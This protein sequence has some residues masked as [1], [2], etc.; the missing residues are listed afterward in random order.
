M[1]MELFDG[2]FIIYKA[3]S[4]VRINYD[5]HPIDILDIEETDIAK[6]T[7]E[8][9][10]RFKKEYERRIITIEGDIVAIT[11]LRPIFFEFKD[12]IE[13]NAVIQYYCL[14]LGYDYDIYQSIVDFSNRYTK[15]VVHVYEPTYDDQYKP[16]PKR[17]F[18]YST[19]NIS[20]WN[21]YYLPIETSINHLNREKDFYDKITFIMRTNLGKIRH[22]KNAFKEFELL[23]DS[24]ELYGNNKETIDIIKHNEIF[25]LGFNSEFSCL[26][27]NYDLV[28]KLIEK[29]FLIKGLKT[30]IEQKDI[31]KEI[32]KV[33][34]KGVPKYDNESIY[35]SFFNSGR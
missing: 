29:K 13:F 30:D 24:V 26:L 3:P 1:F 28:D 2:V 34:E 32:A 4:E 35:K 21:P 22:F 12:M 27:F 33:K 11:K 15:A 5:V 20:E 18:S 17:L 19:Q 31:L 6:S 10:Y 9:L 25:N 23:S 8:T 16:I 14:K 7:V